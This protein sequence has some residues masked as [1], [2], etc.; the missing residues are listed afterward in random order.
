MGIADREYMRNDGGTPSRGAPRPTLWQRLRFA[1]WLF[2][3][4]LLRR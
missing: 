1:L 4:R 2:W 3:R